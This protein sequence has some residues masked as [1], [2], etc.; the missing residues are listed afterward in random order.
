MQHLSVRVLLDEDRLPTHVLVTNREVV[1]KYE[2]HRRGQ[3]TAL[4]GLLNAD[5]VP[6]LL[7]ALR[8]K[9]RVHFEKPFVY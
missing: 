3:P 1:I 6:F 9:E 4:K 2:L 5:V 7:T 8:Q